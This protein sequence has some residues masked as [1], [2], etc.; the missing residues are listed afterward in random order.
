MKHT[1]LSSASFLLIAA[2]SFT[3][4]AQYDDTSADSHRIQFVKTTVKA[5]SILRTV[6]PSEP[7]AIPTPKFVIKSANDN[8]LLT[9]GGQI[10][11]IMGWDIGNNLYKQEGAGSGFTTQCIPV[12]PTPG[13][14][15]DFFINALNG[16]V[17]MTVVGL[18]NTPN[19]IKGYLKVGTNGLSSQLKLK[20]AY[21]TWRGLTTGLKST[22]F[23]DGDACQPPTID[24]EG[25][26][27]CV[28]GNVYEVN[29]TTPSLNG[30]KAAI[31]I[32]VPTFDSSNGVYRGKDYPVFD[33]K[34]VSDFADVEQ[35]MPDI[36]LW[37]EYSASENNRI[38]L[39]GMLRGFSYKDLLTNKT[40]SSM[41][42]GVMLSGNYQPV[43][44]VV[45]YLQA[46]YGKG[47][48]NYI[49][50]ISG[51]PLSFIPKSDRP[52]HMTPAPMMGL[53][54]GF[55]INP[56]DRLQFNIMGSEAR[57]WKVGNYANALD[58]S[59]NYRYALYG[60]VNCFYNITSYLQWGI[61]YLYGRRETWNIGGANDSRIQTQLS[62]TL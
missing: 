19:A 6:R 54:L 18:A 1:L 35:M 9:I 46:V 16:N 29:Y 36:P 26:S 15:G 31:G 21:I 47:I 39:S 48:G 41:G 56:T 10:D 58:E 23:E 8:F 28:S 11:V 45:V 5:D 32:D 52:G 50:D 49:Q 3:A 14:K 12:P 20:K 43:K 37:V 7:N 24:P 53:N 33:G 61:E 22:L 38:R 42:W 30:F 2:T 44:P 59:Q 27:G 60:A 34:Q 51:L 4:T 57:I 55:S 17:D 40:H 25:P 13:H 62:F